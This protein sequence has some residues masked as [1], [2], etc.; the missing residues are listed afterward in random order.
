MPLAATVNAAVWP[1]IN[2]WLAGWFVIAG[3]TKTVNVAVALVTGLPRLYKLYT[4]TYQL[5]AAF[6]WALV[7]VIVQLEP[8]R[9]LLTEDP[10]K[11]QV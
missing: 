7:T 5:P 6:A 10:F 9:E 3:G 2:A 1:R 4:T 11:Y 8:P